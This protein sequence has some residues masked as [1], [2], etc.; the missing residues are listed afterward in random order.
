MES[1]RAG[2]PRMDFFQKIDKSI[3]TA[4]KTVYFSFVAAR[5]KMLGKTYADVLNLL[6]YEFTLPETEE[7]WK[8]RQ[9]LLSSLS[10]IFEQ[11]KENT[12]LPRDFAERVKA[13]LPQIVEAACSERTTLSASACRTLIHIAKNLETQIQ[14]QLDIILPALLVLCGSTKGVNQK[15]AN[16]AITTICQHAGYSPRLFYHICSA[17]R[18]KR[19]P[20][21]TFAPEWLRILL[22]TYRTQMDA[23]KDGHAAQK[24][25]FQGLTDGQVKVRENSRAVYWEFAKHDAQG[26]RMI[27]GGLNSHAQAALRDDP[28]NPDKST[29]GSRAPRP[30]SALAHIKAQQKQRLQQHRGFTPA[31]IKPED[32]IFGSLEGINP[33]PDE[34]H[35]A[36]KA[37]PEH[38]KDKQDKHAQE[39]SHTSEPAGGSRHG[40]RPNSQKSSKD[41]KLDNT[42]DLKTASPQTEAR[43]LLSAPVRRG[44][45]VATPISAVSNNSQRPGSRGEPTKKPVD[46][47]DKTAAEKASGRQTPISHSNK[48]SISSTASH[49]RK[50]ASRHETLKAEAKELSNSTNQS[51]GRK[52]GRQTP[53]IAEDKEPIAPPITEPVK[54]E[55]RRI[56]LIVEE[57]YMSA[58]A[59][60]K[61]I[62]KEN[63]LGEPLPTASTLPLR[64]VQAIAPE[65]QMA[66]PEPAT[67]GFT[68]IEYTPEGK[69]NTNIIQK[70]TYKSPNRP[71]HRSPSRSPK[72]RNSIASAKKSLATAMEFLRHGSLDALGYRR[73][74]KLLENHRSVLITRQAQ[75]NELFELLITNLA[76]LDEIAEPRDKRIGNLNHPA[77]NRHTIVIMLM[78]LFDQYPQYPEP[79]PG[80]T[81]CA[82]IIARCNHSS[83]FASALTAIDMTAHSLC[84]TTPNPLPTI[85]AVLDTLQSIENII[86]DNDPIITPK[87]TTTLLWNSLQSVATDFGPEKPRFSTRL[88]IILAFGLNL[89]NFLL[90]RVSAC[91]QTLYTIQEDRLASYA[92]HLLSTYSSLMRRHIITYCKALHSII[93]PE[94]RFYN[95]FTKESDKNLIHYYVAGA[96]GM[97]TG[98]LGNTG[99][100]VMPEED[101]DDMHM[102]SEPSTYDPG[103]VVSADW[104]L[105]GTT[106]RQ[107]VYGQQMGPGTIDVGRIPFAS[108]EGSSG[109]FEVLGVTADE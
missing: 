94:R 19:N 57:K 105:L 5:A 96:S 101:Y 93:K 98:S 33:T 54:H 107:R 95:Y 87:S 103:S 25:I 28:H 44:R 64:P 58:P 34:K 91:G 30:D 106:L 104:K 46:S 80:M 66:P 86:N 97:P 71:S 82:L 59:V 92:E 13:T 1:L 32:F 2:V 40:S 77:Y 24:A 55:E 52:T 102:I 12:A 84:M 100:V 61:D 108:S 4:G 7:T 39:S 72:R 109:N 11:R 36:P 83:G 31:S 27:M 78:D 38:A 37:A 85:D 49:H 26:A 17:F 6:Q 45:I 8:K 41:S 88:P 90:T 75:F 51:H 29:K 16:D 9:D 69:E 70:H 99:R 73:L 63:V 47:R 76:S 74:R 35:A 81:L 43:P 50:T 79:Q 21:R 22:K 89:L 65:I 20:P 68:T 62:L 15:N 42:K 23:E 53:V 3:A 10:D 56:P 48:D 67:D 18:D 60:Y 14:P